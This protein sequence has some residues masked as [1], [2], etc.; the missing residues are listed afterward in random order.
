MK[1]IYTLSYLILSLNWVSVLSECLQEQTGS[2]QMKNL[3]R[4]SWQVAMLDF[5]PR[6]VLSAEWPLKLGFISQIKLWEKS[7]SQL[8]TISNICESGMT[9]RGRKF[10]KTFQD[11]IKF[12]DFKSWPE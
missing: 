6:C 12:K 11:S 2:E 9:L 10:I 4:N 3:P 8:A 7:K 5:K 1:K